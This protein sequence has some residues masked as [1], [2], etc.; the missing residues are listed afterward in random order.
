[1]KALNILLV[2]D[3]PHDVIFITNALN[4]TKYT[5]NLIAVADGKTC[6]DF[7]AKNPPYEQALRPD[8]IILDINLPSVD[9]IEVLKSIKKSSNKI[10]PVVMLTSSKNQNDIYSS[11]MNYANN[12][13]VK[14][15]VAKDF[16]AVIQEIENFW[17]QI[18][19]IP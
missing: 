5:S 1:M 10:I 15:V 16:I 12:Y 4:Q 8:L 6:L 11:Y 9:G 13:V 3:N 17:S 2:E 7:L 14:P 19:E 18:S